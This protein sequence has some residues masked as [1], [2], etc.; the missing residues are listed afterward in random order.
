VTEEELFRHVTDEI[1]RTQNVLAALTK[2]RLASLGRLLVG[3]TH[4]DVASRVGLSPARIG[5]LATQAQKYST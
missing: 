3:R 1:E 5:Q 4:V 2:I